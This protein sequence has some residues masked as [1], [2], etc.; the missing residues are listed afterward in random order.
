MINGPKFSILASK[1][2]YLGKDLMNLCSGF[3][4]KQTFMSIVV[5][6]DR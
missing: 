2:E 3:G 1:D 4:K 6:S 5:K